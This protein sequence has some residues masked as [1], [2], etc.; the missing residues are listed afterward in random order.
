MNTQYPTCTE[1]SNKGIVH[2]CV[3]ACANPAVDGAE[4]QSSGG[5]KTAQ[6]FHKACFILAG[7]NLNGRIR[8]RS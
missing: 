2:V 1:V 4:A 5:K 8:P 6:S 3:N 7:Y